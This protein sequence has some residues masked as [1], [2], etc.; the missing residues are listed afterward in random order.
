MAS[1]EKRLLHGKITQSL[2]VHRL[3]SDTSRLAYTWLIPFLDCEGRA[4]GNPQLLAATLF[5]WRVGVDISAEMME[6]FVREW[7]RE[8]LVI[9]YKKGDAL[10]IVF[11]TFFDHQTGF[12]KRKEPA[13][14]VPEPPAVWEAVCPIDLDA[15]PEKVKPP[16]KAVENVPTTL[17]EPLPAGIS[18]RL[19]EKVETIY[20]GKRPGARI[21]G[22]VAADV[23]TYG[24]PATLE[25]A[26]RAVEHNAHAWKYVSTCLS[27]DAQQTLRETE[28]KATLPSSNEPLYIDAYKC[29]VRPDGQGGWAP[30][31]C[32]EQGEWVLA[33]LEE[34]QRGID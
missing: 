20:R 5:P 6:G 31:K 23:Q 13:S 14:I 8:Q 21:L 17:P 19:M 7:H 3:G 28:H 26:C 1:R 2:Q 25:A 24:E 10:W 16:R 12:D 32:T 18:T 11:P 4:G 30:V 15:H 33:T 27:N 29:Y 9:W 34:A 22:Q